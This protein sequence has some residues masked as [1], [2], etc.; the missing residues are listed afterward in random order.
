[1][2]FQPSLS[3][4]LL[5]CL[6]LYQAHTPKLKF[7]RK[8]YLRCNLITILK[9]Y[10]IT[11]QFI[12]RFR[13]VVIELNETWKSITYGQIQNYPITQSKT[14]YAVHMKL[15]AKSNNIEWKS[16]TFH[17]ILHKSSIKLSNILS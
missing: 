10:D 12:P 16:N 3:T 11:K 7:S 15:S 1:M 9:V 8:F 6:F 14:C 13:S 4:V 17:S 2:H 5:E